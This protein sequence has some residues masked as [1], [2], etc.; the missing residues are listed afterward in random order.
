MLTVDG[1]VIRGEDDWLYGRVGAESIGEWVEITQAMI[2]KFAEATHDFQFIHVDR[3]AAR[4]TPMGGTVAHGFLSLSLLSLLASTARDALPT[5][6]TR[7]ILNYGCNKL[8]F[9]APVR[10]G[11]R[12]RGRFKVLEIAEK[13]PGQYLQT[14]DFIVEIEGESRPALFA[15]WIVLIFVGTEPAARV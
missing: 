4:N 12:V 10:S 7:M 11:A 2:D 5:T 13:R 9:V 14:M 3:E 15:E 6:G 1:P 8:R